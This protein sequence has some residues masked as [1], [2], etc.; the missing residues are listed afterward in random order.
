[1]KIGL[2]VIKTFLCDKDKYEFVFTT[3]PTGKEKFL[4]EVETDVL[5]NATKCIIIQ[6]MVQGKLGSKPHMYTW[7]NKPYKIGKA[8][9]FYRIL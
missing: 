3:E 2:N 7:L 8:K 9:F 4:F 1:M 5:Y 6:D